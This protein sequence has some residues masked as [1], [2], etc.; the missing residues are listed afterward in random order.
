MKVFK[1]DKINN[2]ECIKYQTICFI[3]EQDLSGIKLPTALRFILK[4]RMLT[5]FIY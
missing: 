1:D 2:E 4:K 5:V 3:K